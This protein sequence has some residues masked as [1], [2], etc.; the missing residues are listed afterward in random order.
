MYEFLTTEETREILA[1]VLLYGA[2]AILVIFYAGYRYGL[3]CKQCGNWR[4]K[5]KVRHYTDEHQRGFYCEHIAVTC[6]RCGVL[7]TD[8]HTMLPCGETRFG[9]SVPRQTK[10]G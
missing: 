9:V 6:R 5:R 8:S 4:F 3:R 10:R 7:I 2:C 1:K